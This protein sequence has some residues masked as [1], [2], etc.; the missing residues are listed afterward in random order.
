MA[1]HQL[2]NAFIERVRAGRINRLGRHS[3]GGG[4]Y[5][6]IGKVGPIG[7]RANGHERGSASWVFRYAL[8]GQRTYLGGGSLADVGLSE[9]RRWAERQRAILAAGGDPRSEREAEA[10]RLHAERSAIITFKDEAE[11]VLAARDPAIG[12]IKHN[13]QWGASLR[14]YAYP[15]IGSHP[16]AT[17]ARRDVLNV[18]EPIWTKKYATARRVRQRIEAVI[19]AAIAREVR[20]DENNP[21]RWVGLKAV[22]GNGRPPVVH[23]AAMP[24][25]RLPAFLK[26]LRKVPGL[27]AR[28]LELTVLTGCRT[29]E[30][31]GARWDEFDFKRGIWIIPPS[32]TKAK[33]EHRV[34]LAEPAL[35]L[36][37]GVAASRQRGPFVF[38]GI[39]KEERPLSNM[40]MLMTLRRLKLSETVH[41]FRS[42]MRD[43]FADHGHSRELAEAALGHA[44]KNAVERAYFRSD[45]LERRR[46]L[47]A[48]W[49]A[50][51]DGSR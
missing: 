48:Q 36:L 12:N 16:I 38:P 9:A 24:W 26:R 21:A 2:D 43:W 41:G 46:G 31:L 5:L 8:A 27:S 29:G 32:R 47:M 4:L 45:L 28:A 14:R 11:R 23:H 40:S 18:L 30:V 1:V 13:K 10:A 3:D 20:S 6:K 33:R 37:H 25:R 35:A 19:D 51:C 22:L 39:S 7:S 15:I 17:L 44:V 50:F 49:A 42:A 34:P